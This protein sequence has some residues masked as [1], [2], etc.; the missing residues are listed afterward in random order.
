MD[1]LTKTACCPGIDQTMLI[2]DKTMI[3]NPIT[4]VNSGSGSIYNLKS[5]SWFTNIN[6]TKSK[7][8]DSIGSA[9][10]AVDSVLPVESINYVN[11]K[12]TTSTEYLG[13]MIAAGIKSN[14]GNVSQ[15]NIFISQV[16]AITEAP[17][18]I[19]A[20]GFGNSYSGM[21]KNAMIPGL[22]VDS[23]VPI[24]SGNS[25]VN[26]GFLIDSSADTTLRTVEN[27]NGFNSGRQNLVPNALMETI[28]KPLFFSVTP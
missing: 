8:A 15:P 10:L 18:F 3:S 27:S 16:G 12:P 26:T 17:D 24:F 21:P 5:D 25:A 20:G 1:D 9:D 7:T 28:R 11:T 19:R 22:S 14:F 2:H 4:N 23:G 13:S 6:Y